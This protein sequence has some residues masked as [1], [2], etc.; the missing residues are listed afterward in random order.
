MCY[1]LFPHSARVLLTTE[2]M[3]PNFLEMVCF[4]DRSMSL[5][6]A[7]MAGATAAG[8][9]SI[10]STR[11]LVRLHV[12]RSLGLMTHWIAVSHPPPYVG[13]IEEED[14]LS[15]AAAMCLECLQ[16]C[17]LG[18]SLCLAIR[19]RVWTCVVVRLHLMPQ[20]STDPCSVEGGGRCQSVLRCSAWVFFR[21]L[22]YVVITDTGWT[23]PPTRLF[24]DC[25]WPAAIPHSEIWSTSPE[26]SR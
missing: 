23:F 5:T 21:A 12:K 1:I 18:F 16:Q 8:K 2:R 10:D 9:S 20:C 7:F 24:P 25:L 19:R 15:R 4:K 14:S 17:H 3:E 26:D 6:T 13:M 22:Y 11:D